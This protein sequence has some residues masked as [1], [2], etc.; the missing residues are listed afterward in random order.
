M[1][2][3]YFR[4]IQ[5]HQKQ[6][7]LQEVIL[8]QYHSHLLLVIFH[9]IESHTDQIELVFH[10]LHSSSMDSVIL[11]II[12]DDPKCSFSLYASL[13][14]QLYSCFTVQQFLRMCLQVIEY[15]IDTHHSFLGFRTVLFEWTSVTCLA[16]PYLCYAWIVS[17]CIRN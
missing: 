12:L 7:V 13:L 15:S 17:L 6:P 14:S 9:Q 2:Y 11:P 4:H 10:I 3:I 8:V 5:A 16:F 1:F